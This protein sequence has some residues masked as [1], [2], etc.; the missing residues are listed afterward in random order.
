MAY[1][2]GRAGKDQVTARS[3]KRRAKS[4]GRAAEK[5][6][7]RGP[8]G[9]QRAA[10]ERG[11]VATP[12][13]SAAFAS[14]EQA[15]RG[16]RLTPDLDIA[17]E[18]AVERVL[19][20]TAADHVEISWLTNIPTQRWISHVGGL[21]VPGC[22]SGTR[23]PI[24]GTPLETAIIQGTLASTEP[25]KPAP[26]ANE[27][28]VVAHAVLFRSALAAPLI[29]DDGIVGAI[30]VYSRGQDVFGR[31]D[32]DNLSGIAGR[33]GE[34]VPLSAG[35]IRRSLEAVQALAR[36]LAKE[37]RDLL[38]SSEA[39][40]EFLST[41][42]SQVRTPL[43]GIRA[44]TDI[45]L[46]NSPRNLTERQMQQLKILKRNGWQLA[47]LIDDLAHLSR[48]ESGT[49]SREPSDS[50]FRRLRRELLENLSPI[51]KVPPQMPWPELPMRETNL[52]ADRDRL[53]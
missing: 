11:P 46:L 25:E 26:E 15:I 9:S 40:S 45:L 10:T 41:V 17:C 42:A 8:G 33:L 43:I 12:R 4:H 50:D 18:T 30:E 37:K 28:P 5:A 44:L 14:L 32:T 3:G 16:T 51:L 29:S 53:A 39:I 1:Q 2:G 49:L 19:E 21:A 23:R 38:Q 34:R 24:A 31:R 36:R 22:D 27:P 52:E 20:R 6:S 48:I 13:S 7:R 35:A 47:L